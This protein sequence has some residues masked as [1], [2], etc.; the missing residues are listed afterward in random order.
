M[1]VRVGSRCSRLVKLAVTGL[2]SISGAGSL[3]A[4]PAFAQ[5]VI[6]QATAPA[7]VQERQEQD[8][9]VRPE[10]YDVRLHP[11]SEVS[12]W[13]NILWTTAIVE[14][15]QS[16]VADAFSQ[17][18]A[19][20]AQPGLSDAQ[21]RTV[22]MAMQVGTQLYKA[23]PT[24]YAAIGQ[25]FAQTIERSPDAEWV[26]MSLAAMVDVNTTPAQRQQWSDFVRQ[27]FPNWASNVYLYSTLQAIATM[28]QPSA[29]PPL[30]DLLSWTI[31]P[32]QPQMYVLCRP[33]RNVLCQAVVKDRNGQFLQQNGQLWSVPLLLRSL[34]GLSWVFTRGQTP[35]GIYRIEGTVPQPDTEYFR[36]YGLF[37]LVNLFVPFES[38]A[39]EF[40]P[41]QSGTLRGNLT[42]YQALLPP[43][44][45]NYFPM[46]E[47]YW[48]G[49][50][51]RGAFRIHGSG[52]APTF[53]SNSKQFPASQDW[54]P[55]IG[56]LSALELYDD[57]GQLQQA[58]MP[59]ILDALTSAAGRRNFTGYLI[60]VDVPGSSDTPISLAD[61]EGILA[62]SAANA[63]AASA[64]P[65]AL[66]Y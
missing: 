22:Q 17:L 50:A 44:W 7:R 62:Q 58:D 6:P 48:A 15:R 31:A 21:Q 11:A 41:G 38:G 65:N 4:S 37:P 32:G 1:K 46:Q 5:R 49:R 20:A 26:A 18:I 47:T 53:F 29:A 12:H 51:G 40:V 9:Q 33:N 55:T 61:I 64:H 3:F 19:L 42:T 63:T 30:A 54:I 43:S 16:Y 35:Q 28:D 34:N 56:C 23:D 59:K 36:A 27:R 8:R 57:A 60:V 45:R 13:R 24:T 39:R 66:T 14:P 10:N 2:V 25:Q 52:E